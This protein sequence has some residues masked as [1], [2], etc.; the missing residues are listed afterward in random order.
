MSNNITPLAYQHAATDSMGPNPAP[1]PE[2]RRGPYGPQRPFSGWVS[3][4]QNMC[5]CQLSESWVWVRPPRPP[6]PPGVGGRQRSARSAPTL[7]NAAGARTPPRGPFRVGS[8]FDRTCAPANFQKV[9]FGRV[10]RVHRVH[11]N[12]PQRTVIIS[13]FESGRGPGQMRAVERGP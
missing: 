3:I 1:A 11:Q 6:R 5:T 10:H 9:G 4:R 8:V 2:R 7:R 13:D 12:P